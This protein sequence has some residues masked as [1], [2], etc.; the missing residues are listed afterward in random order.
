MV[1]I[2]ARVAA[3]SCLLAV[4]CNSVRPDAAPKAA[5]PGAAP[6]AEKADWRAGVT[7]GLERIAEGGSIVSFGLPVPDGAVADPAT[8]RVQV[9]ASDDS[10]AGLK[11]RPI[12]FRYGPDGRRRGIRSLLIQFPAA[13]MTGKTVNVRVRWRGEGP[14]PAADTRP[15]AGA[16]MPSPEIARVVNRRIASEGGQYR[17]VERNPADIT[18]YARSSRAWWRTIRPAIWPPPGCSASR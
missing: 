5:G 9:G 3:L 15:Y 8:V 7:V 18:L 2:A 10:V 17:L 16:A 14:A 11:V 13:A 1:S 4:S 6:R 12:L